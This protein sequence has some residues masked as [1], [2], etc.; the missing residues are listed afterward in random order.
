MRQR[1]Q[2][3]VLLLLTTIIGVLES[4]MRAMLARYILVLV[5]LIAMS[6]RLT[7]TMFDL[8]GRFKLN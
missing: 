6:L 8:F 3:E 1:Q 7:T 2:M 4:R 5:K